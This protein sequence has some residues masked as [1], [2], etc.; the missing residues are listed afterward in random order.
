MFFKNLKKIH[1][2]WELKK[3]MMSE[4]KQTILFLPLFN[5]LEDLLL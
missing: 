3:Q 5:I 4:A 1:F 2:S